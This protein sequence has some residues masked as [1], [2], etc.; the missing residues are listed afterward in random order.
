MSADPARIAA[1]RARVDEATDGPW[2]VCR[3]EEISIVSE[4]GPVIVDQVCAESDEEIIDRD[5]D[6]DFIAHAREDIPYLLDQLAQQAQEIQAL[7]PLQPPPRAWI[8]TERWKNGS[9]HIEGIALTN[10]A[11]SAWVHGGDLE[12]GHARTSLPYPVVPP[13]VPGA[14]Q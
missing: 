1:I 9:D 2:R 13:P 11:A 10:A 4:V 7:R 14:D 12:M 5:Y 6:A 8:L 3:A